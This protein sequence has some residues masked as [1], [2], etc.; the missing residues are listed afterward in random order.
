M[1][2]GSVVDFF[3]HASFVFLVLDLP[4]NSPLVPSSPIPSPS[5]AKMSLMHSQ[6]LLN[7]RIPVD[8]LF[9]TAYDRVIYLMCRFTG[10]VVFA[11][12][13]LLALSCSNRVGS[14]RLN[15]L[16]SISQPPLRVEDIRSLNSHLHY[17]RAL[18]MMKQHEIAISGV[19]KHFKLMQTEI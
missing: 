10:V 12:I 15:Q 4:V 9:V 16:K 13:C 7:R 2:S 17:L 18:S 5:H 8:L 6:L 3:H 11:K 14:G 1:S 19:I